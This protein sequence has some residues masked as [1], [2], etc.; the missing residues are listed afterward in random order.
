MIG[1]YAARAEPYEYV[2]PFGSWPSGM[3]ARGHYVASLKV[4][5]G[6]YRGGGGLPRT[7][8][9]FCSCQ[10]TSRVVRRRVWSRVAGR[11]SLA[12]GCW[13]FG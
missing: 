12:A 5:H 8:L 2:T 11:G 1:S 3:L 10:H 13:L 7:A 6:A 4:W 9:T